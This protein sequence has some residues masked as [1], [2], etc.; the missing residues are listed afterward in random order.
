MTRVTAS[1]CDSAAWQGTSR[2]RRFPWSF[3]RDFLIHLFRER[4]VEIR[5]GGFHPGIDHSAV[6]TELGRDLREDLALLELVA[7]D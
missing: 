7:Q 4:L 3:F 6:E 5:L 1:L 2:S